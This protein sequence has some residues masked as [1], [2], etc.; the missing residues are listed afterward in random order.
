MKKK[1]R[2]I[3]IIAFSI[4]IIFSC[5]RFFSKGHTITY[6]L[7]EEVEVR[8]IY[9]RRAKKE[10]DN[11]YFEITFQKHVF[12]FQFYHD[13]SKRR[14]V[15][16]EV[17]T[18]DGEYQ[19]VLPIIEGSAKTDILCYQDN[20]YYFYHDIIGK[21]SKLD[22]FVNTIDKSLYTKEDWIDETTE[23]KVENNITF[24]PQNMVPEHI[25]LLSNF[26]GIYLLSDKVENISIFEKDIYQ[27]KLSAVVSHYYVVADYA[28]NNQF[29]TFYFVDLRNGKMTEAKAPNYVSFDSY[30]QGI[31]D[32]KLYIYDK[33]NEKQYRISP[34]KKEVKEIGNSKKK[35]QYYEDGKWTKITTTKANKELTFL[36]EEKDM[37]FQKYID[38]YHFGKE[39]SGYY[40]LLEKVEEGYRLYRTPSQNKQLVTFIAMIPSKENLYFIDDYVYFQDGETMKVYQDE[41]GLHTVFQYSELNFN[42]NLLFGVAKK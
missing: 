27:K 5:I 19:C 10:I 25:L 35:I 40:Y 37:D 14:K 34:E 30:I 11:Y 36:V 13:F 29:R 9:T 7:G 6:K 22:D 2:W 26:K 8:E 24:Y 31:V 16:E 4:L 18:Y 1:K 28:E 42:E 39:K 15:I 41:I 32:E 3:L 23:G 21:E 17:L 38:V 20:R 12:G 33:D